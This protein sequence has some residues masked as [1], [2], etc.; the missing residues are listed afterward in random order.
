MLGGGG[1][2][3]QEGN[4]VTGGGGIA[5]QDGSAIS[6]GG[7]TAEQEGNAVIGG[8]GIAEQDGS[9]VTGGGGIA[10]QDGSAVLGGGG[11]TDPDNEVRGGGGIAEQASAVLGGGGI[12][13]PERAGLSALAGTDCA[14]SMIASPSS[15][16]AS[17]HAPDSIHSIVQRIRLFGNPRTKPRHPAHP[18]GSFMIVSSFGRYLSQSAHDAPMSSCLLVGVV[19]AP[20]VG[21]EGAGRRRRTGGA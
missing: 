13:A 14:A 17:D 11:M 12:M 2:A 18:A 21:F 6:G 8:G 10:E 1:T 15:S 9:A 4:A 19:E 5:E 20:G 3:E 7:G 16:P